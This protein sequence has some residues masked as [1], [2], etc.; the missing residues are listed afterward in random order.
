VIQKKDVRMQVEQKIDLEE[1]TS[2]CEMKS[3]EESKSKKTMEI[4]TPKKASPKKTIALDTKTEDENENSQEDVK[5]AELGKKS[6]MDKENENPKPKIPV[7]SSE[8]KAEDKEQKSDTDKKKAEFP[9]R[10]KKMQKNN[11]RKAQNHSSPHVR[12]KAKISEPQNNKIYGVYLDRSNHKWKATY[13]Y[14]GI[15]DH[16]GYFDTKFEATLVLQQYKRDL[17]NF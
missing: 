1:K 17:R 6:E 11:K 12:K 2:D 15:Q 4:D 5:E 9:K 8:K 3:T 13:T 16:L 10:K 14:M 7:V